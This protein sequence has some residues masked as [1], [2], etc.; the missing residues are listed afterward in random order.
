MPLVVVLHG[1]QTTAYQQMEASLYN[2]LADKMGFVVVYPDTDAAE[3]AQPGPAGPLLAV[4]PSPGCE[5]RS[6]AMA[7]WWP[8]SP[9]E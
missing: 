9:A 5:T 4:L 7:P 8:G 6:R 3:N 1:C 2:P